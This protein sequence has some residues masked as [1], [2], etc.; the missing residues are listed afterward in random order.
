MI[1]RRYRRADSA[2]SRRI[3]TALAASGF[4]SVKAFEKATSLPT[5]A[6]GTFLRTSNQQ[7]PQR[8]RM[9]MAALE[10]HLGLP[11]AEIATLAGIVPD[12]RHLASSLPSG[13]ILDHLRDRGDITP[14]QVD[15]ARWLRA[16]AGGLSFPGL[17]PCRSMWRAPLL[18]AW[19]ALEAADAIIAHQHRGCPPA[20]FTVWRV[21]IEGDR[22]GW[23]S[24]DADPEL[25][26][27]E[28][29]ALWTG[30]EALAAAVSPP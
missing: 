26:R 1:H 8:R 30:L 27:L 22:P 29:L 6:L 17:H 5:L 9:V 28:R 15:A 7:S 24:P 10:S 4:T 3:K 16:A 18:A 21:V 23:L 25:A 14:R 20:S 13:D 2:L 11:V 19:S 12:G